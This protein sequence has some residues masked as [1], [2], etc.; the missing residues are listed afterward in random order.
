[1][2]RR[3]RGVPAGYA[4]PSRGECKSLPTRSEPSLCTLRLHRCSPEKRKPVKSPTFAVLLLCPAIAFAPPPNPADYPV[5]VHVTTSRIIRP[6]NQAGQAGQRIQ[7]VIEGKKY[8]LQGLSDGVLALGDYKAK[9]KEI[10][11]NSYDIYKTYEILMPDGK[12]RN[13]NLTGILG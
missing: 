5:N 13:F 7:V 11:R 3:I 10:H 2:I 9:L 1:M 4:N 12:I 8:E 6:I